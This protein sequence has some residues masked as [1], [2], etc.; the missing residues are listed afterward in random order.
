MS[1][2]PGPI[3]SALESAPPAKKNQTLLE[4]LRGV[5]GE[6]IANKAMTTIVLA[7]GAV[8]ILLPLVFM[9]GT[10]FK[11]ATQLKMYPPPI[12]PYINTTVE[13]NGEQYMLYEVT[14]ENGEKQQMA[15]VKK[16]PGGMGFFV[17]PKTPDTQVKLKIKDQKQLQHLQSQPF[18]IYFINTCIVTFVGMF[19]MLVSSSMVAYG[20]SRF[21]SKTLSVLF[22][23]L[24]STM[25]L[26]EQVRLIPLY[27][28][29]QK[30]GWI[31]S[32][33]PLI[34]PA[35]FA[36]AYDVFLLRQFFLTIPLEMDD[37]AK[38]DGANRLQSYL[39]VVLPQ[40]IPALFSVCILHFIWA[41]N[42]FYEPLIFL[43]SQNKWTI[44]VG[45]QTFNALYTENTHL[46]MAASVVLVIPP[47]LLFLLSQRIFVQGV[48]I[49][50]VKG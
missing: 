27:I 35:F 43:H 14:N 6:G 9:F 18:G 13:V 20:F 15:L 8:V 38:I 10:S 17:D 19:G 28:L 16:A 2:D 24:L 7:I 31:D 30:I 21:R 25:M 44:A 12:L 39:Y 41:W 3:F 33:L 40:S 26:P 47:I 32:L 4:M 23:V 48:V 29:F 37:A 42:D 22:I 11:N 46:I 50:G 36:S 34:V 5:K 49:S 45:L 1:S